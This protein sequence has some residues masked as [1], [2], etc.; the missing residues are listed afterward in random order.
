MSTSTPLAKKFLKDLETIE[1]LNIVY[2]TLQFNLKAISDMMPQTKGVRF[3]S[4]DEGVTSKSF[5][6]HEVDINNEAIE[7]LENNEATQI[8]G[9]LDIL[10]K[11][12]TIMLTQSGT[13]LSFTSLI[14]LS[15]KKFPMLEFAVATLSAI[16]HL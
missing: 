2:S 3:N 16:N 10:G 12:R 14:D 9:I 6:G 7:A 5:S 1:E 15:D 4:N 13:I 8:I 11:A